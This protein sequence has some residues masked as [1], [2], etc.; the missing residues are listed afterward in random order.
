MAKV[1]KKLVKIIESFIKMG[2]K[3]KR[4]SKTTG[5]CWKMCFKLNQNHEKKVVENHQ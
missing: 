4:L 1:D 2:K 3:Y 5:K